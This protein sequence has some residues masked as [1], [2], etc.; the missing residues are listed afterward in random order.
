MT[1]GLEPTS[2][3]PATTWVRDLAGGLARRGHRVIVL[4]T[5]H[6][7]GAVTSEAADPAGVEVRRPEPGG[8]SDAVERAL[9]LEPD[10]VHLAA[11]GS[12]AAES[13]RALEDSALLIDLLDWSPLCPAADLLRR[14]RTVGC[15]SQH[16]A[17]PCDE[18]VGPVHVAAAEPFMAL[19]H[20]GHPLLAHSSYARDRATLALGRGVTLLPVGVDPQLFSRENARAV[21]AEVRALAANREHSRA[22]LLGPPS[23]ARGSRAIM[24]LLVALHAR[25]PGIELVVTGR[26]AA[27]PRSLEI[28]RTEARELGV[29]PQLVLLPDLSPADLPAL[30]AACDVGVAPGLAP[31]AT[32]LPIIQALAVG[33]PVVAHPIGA[34]PELLQQ[35]EAGVLADAS[36]VGTF[37]DEVAA[38]LADSK[39]RAALGEKGRLA[40]LE[41][42]DLDRAIYDTEALYDRVRL[43]RSR[44]VLGAGEFP[45]RRR[46]AA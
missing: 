17:A 28:V 10:V 34:A 25:V 42:H 33:L 30:L 35:D 11:P 38:L 22:V 3:E 40:A 43:P 8:L 1:R 12:L 2:L 15:D 36:Q 13:F 18:C 21:A 20:G 9:E 29:A 41:R 7:G 23:P 31:D 45:R 27:E 32:G 4:C 44:R 24:D 5:D 46:K 37:A 16:P 14:T 39:R 6:G 19:A 26:D